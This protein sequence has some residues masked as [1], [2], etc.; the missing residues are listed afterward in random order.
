MEHKAQKRFGQNFLINNKICEN[1][2]ELLPI[3]DGDVLEIG[4][5]KG[6]L[7]KYAIEKFKK[8]NAVEIDRDLFN[9]LLSTFSNINV[10]NKN[11]KKM[12]IE[13]YEMIF[14]NIPYNITTEILVKCVKEAQN[15]EFLVFMVQKEAFE[16]IV[17]AELKEE[18]TPLSVILKIFY[19][20]ELL[21]NV[22]REQFNPAPRVDSVVFKLTNL[23]KYK[24]INLKGFY[25]YLLILFSSRRKNI[26]NNLIKMYDKDMVVKTLTSLNILKDFRAE[27]L[28]EDQ[29]INIYRQLSKIEG[30]K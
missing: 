14:G 5:G 28:D 8:Y 17:K 22:G 20:Y 2:V 10:T 3:T 11:F 19:D 26:Q 1:I 9:Y 15:A 21:L 16:R 25:T 13:S 30:E 18:K 24:D 29:Y 4:P 27:D 12:S 6:A 7:T 23:N